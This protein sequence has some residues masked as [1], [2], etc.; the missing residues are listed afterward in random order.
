MTR[1]A[2]HAFQP[3]FAGAGDHDGDVSRPSSPFDDLDQPV[4]RLLRNDG[5]AA[6]DVIEPG[7]GV[8]VDLDR[9]RVARMRDAGV[10]PTHE[11]HVAQ[12][13]RRIAGRTP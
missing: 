4:I 13:D 3:V 8:S 11:R 1:F 9:N 5:R 10:L 2:V 12:P 7:L 6:C